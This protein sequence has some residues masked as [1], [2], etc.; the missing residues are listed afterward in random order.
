MALLCCNVLLS[1]NNLIYNPGFENAKPGKAPQCDYGFATGGH[2]N[3]EEDIADWLNGHTFSGSSKRS[4]PDWM[5]HTCDAIPGLTYNS[6]FVYLSKKYSDSKS[7]DALRTGLRSTMNPVQDY[8]FRITYVGVSPKDA[9]ELDQ[10]EVARIYLTKLGPH[11]NKSWGNV[12][13]SFPMY[14]P[15]YGGGWVQHY[16]MLGAGFGSLF[17]DLHNITIVCERGEFYIDYVELDETCASPMLLQSHDFQHGVN[18]LPYKSGSYLK[19]GYNVG[20]AGPTGNVTI[21]YGATEVFKAEDYVQ[22]ESGFSA[23][24]GSNFSTVIEPCNSM[25]ASR[26]MDTTAFTVVDDRIEKIGCDDIIHIQGLDG[27][28]SSY[29]NFHWDFGNGQTSTNKSVNIFY[30]TPGT[31]KVTMIVT[32]SVGVTDTLTKTY[33]KDCSYSKG[34]LSVSK[35]VNEKSQVTVSPNPNSGIFTISASG[36][37]EKQVVIYNVVGK[38]IYRRDHVTEQRLDIDLSDQAKGVYFVKVI[39]GNVVKTEKVINQ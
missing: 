3:I 6:R 36:E 7:S 33:V 4:Y 1:Q 29:Y 2:I 18:E 35:A 14:P 19:A 11:W 31:Y 23:N 15:S 25:S 10:S 22:L 5:N 20:G 34:A 9:G 24:Y 26:N 32:D 28:T 16:T 30:R 17:N 27:D 8:E 21:N 37:D 38:L 13:L 12:K 39:F